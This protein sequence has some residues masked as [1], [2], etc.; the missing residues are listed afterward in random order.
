MPPLSVMFKTVSSD[1]N[2]DCSYCYYRQ[3]MEGVRAQRRLDAVLLERFMPLYMEYI[4]DTH[5]ANLSWQGGEPTLA[6]LDF[7]RLVVELEAKYASPPLVIDNAIQTNAVLLDDRWAEFFAEYRFLVGVSLDG[8]EDIH[9]AARKDRGGNGSYRRVMAGIEALRK[10]SVELNILCVVS[11][12]N[13]HM[14]HDLMQF[15]RREGLTYLQF[16]P[17]MDFQSTEPYKPPTYLINPGQ[18]GEFLAALFDEWYGEGIP[19]V[20]IR[21]FDNFIQSL[22]GVNND[23]CVHSGSCDSGLVIEY[24]GDVFP[25]DFY[26][27]PK[28]W[29]GNVLQDSLKNMLESGVRRRFIR[30][31]EHPPDACVQCQWKNLCKSEC[32]RNWRASPMS[33]GV[34]YF[35]QSYRMLFEHAGERLNTLAARLAAYRKYMAWCAAHKSISLNGN[36]PCPCGSGHK[37]RDCCGNPAL[38]G[39]YLF[40]Q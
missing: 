6:G 10:R 4:A 3:S 34:S 22:L 9:D 39:S 36:V 40:Q 37:F 23:L 26:V 7:F 24:N 12:H 35:C 14:A 17:A 1:C 33:S 30:R 15:Y 21:T 25:C 13:V 29:L 31:R 5:R 2:L 16:I 20:S 11:P 18:Y 28:W 38:G 8:P 19:R 32:P 27:H